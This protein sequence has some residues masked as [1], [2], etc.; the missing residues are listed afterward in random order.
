M[1]R[2]PLSPFR[3]GGLAEGGF[4]SDP[5]MSLHRQMNRLFD[6]VFRGATGQMPSGQEQGGEGGMLMP[7]MDVSETDRELTICAEL[8]GVSEKDIDIR[9]EDDVLVIQAEKKFERKDEQENYHFM[10]RSYGT[11]QRAL[12]LPGPI[13]PDQ[14][15][16]RFE[17][18]VLTVTV[19]KSEQQER[20]R[21]IQIQGGS[22]SGESG[23]GSEIKGESGAAGGKGSKGSSR[24]KAS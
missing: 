16:A 5:F 13:D 23:G 8:P 18:G 15:Q 19:P 4:G 2:N 9:L 20:S 3:T 7:Q 14:V 12:R 24:P 6:D 11:F 10:E 1:A 22:R 17:N 21:R